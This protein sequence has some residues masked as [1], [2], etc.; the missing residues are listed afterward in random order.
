M[1]PLYFTI[2]EVLTT[3]TLDLGGQL[4][5]LRNVPVPAPTEA[6]A[7]EAL[8]WQ[9]PDTTG[10]SNITAVSPAHTGP[11]DGMPQQVLTAGDGGARGGGGRSGHHS[12]HARVKRTKYIPP[13]VCESSP[14]SFSMMLRARPGSARESSRLHRVP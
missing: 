11:T 8:D 7:S 9:H 10:L 4:A 6:L 2:S 13:E 3:R 5:V 14:I 12:Q 1:H